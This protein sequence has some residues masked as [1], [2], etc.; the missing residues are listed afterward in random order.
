MESGAASIVSIYGSLSYGPSTLPL[1]H[2]CDVSIIKLA[3]LTPNHLTSNH[4]TAKIIKGELLKRRNVYTRNMLRKTVFF[5]LTYPK[6]M[7]TIET[8]CSYKLLQRRE[9][10]HLL[11]AIRRHMFTHLRPLLIR[12]LMIRR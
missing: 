2:C 1:R 5:D 7:L 9:D 6:I 4:S 11:S 3:I 12:C 8:R 10:V